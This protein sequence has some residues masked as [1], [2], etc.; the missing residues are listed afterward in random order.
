MFDFEYKNTYSCLEYNLLNFDKKN[1]SKKF[2]RDFKNNFKNDGIAIVKIKTNNQH[3]II[4][5]F[6]V[7][8]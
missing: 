7:S 6:K 1:K 4:P 3:E 8:D 2:I 5:Q